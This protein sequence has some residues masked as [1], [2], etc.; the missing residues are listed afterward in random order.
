MFQGR[1]LLIA[2]KHGKEQVLAPLLEQSLGVVCFTHSGFDT[3]LLGTFSGEVERTLDPISAVREKCRLSA[4]ASGC[5]LVLGSE[6]SFGP[7]PLIP[8]VHANEEV[9]LFMDVRNNIEIMARMVSTETNFNRRILE[10]L[11]ALHAF[12]QE[13]GFPEHALILRRAVHEPKEIVK[14]IRDIGQLHEVFH[15]FREQFGSV[16]A[17][18]D[19]RAMHNP[20][21][22]SVIGMA[23]QQLARKIKSLCPDCGMPGFDVSEVRK[24]LECALCGTAT[25][26]TLNHLYRCA[27]CACEREEWYPH[28][29][30][31]Q[32]PM[33]CDVC[34]P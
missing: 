34:N 4:E 21:R 26:A 31:K 6:G 23:G 13:C 10:D 7:H 30:K 3:D 12:A 20:T 29:K 28:G 19:M 32:D 1:R 24:G 16:Y 17:E 11:D 2:T 33:Y 27:H 14:G 25:G 15:R 18:T 8:F 22:M 5:D 9:L